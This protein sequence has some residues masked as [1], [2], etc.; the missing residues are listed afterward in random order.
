TRSDEAT[1]HHAERFEQ[2][3]QFAVAS[4]GK[5]ELVPMIGAFA[6]AV[7]ERRDLRGAVGE[8][9]AF[10][11]SALLL[12]GERADDPHRVLA[13]DAVAWMHQTIGQLAGSREEQ[14]A[15]AVAVEPPDRD[16]TGMTQLRKLVEN[17]W[18]AFGVA[19]ADDLSGRLVIKQDAHPR[20][21]KAQP[22]EL[23]VDTHLIVGTDFL[24]HFG[25]LT[26]HGDPS[27]D[28]HLFQAAQRTI[29]ALR[30]HLVQ[31]LRFGKDG[32]SEASVGVLSAALV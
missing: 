31:A 4:F 30:Q 24:A 11:Q 12:L 20:S 9:H 25:G 14:Q 21:S 32:L 10:E 2:P 17:R 26:V 19:S 5:R 13:L 7:C 29:T 28:D 18:S 16:P 27:G 1:H 3:A 23:A 22:Y 8:R 15:F 6:A